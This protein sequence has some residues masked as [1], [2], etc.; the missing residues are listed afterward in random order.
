MNS[1]RVVD[2]HAASG[3]SVSRDCQRIALPKPFLTRLFAS[4]A[5]LLVVIHVIAQ[6]VRFSTG[7]DRLFGLVYLFALGAESN[8]PTLYSALSLLTCAALLAL[9]GA[10]A[11]SRQG[12]MRSYWIG[13]AAIFVFLG[14]DEIIGIHER[15]IEPVR[16]ALGTRG[17]LHYAWVVPYGIATLMI[18]LLYCRFLRSIARRSALLFIAA[19]AIFVTG[20]LGFEMIGGLIFEESGDRSLSYIVVQSVEEAL[21]MCGI[22]L[23]IYALEDY[24]ARELGGVELGIASRVEPSQSKPARRARLRRRR[25][26]DGAPE[27]MP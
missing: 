20:A 6:I 2:M 13:L 5:A 10:A 18:G 27:A 24:I 7:D 17:A 15:L 26:V 1:E 12:A 19:G 21:E 25:L 14:A 11:A 23:F 22:V 3:H 9:I 16:A 8:V 4:V